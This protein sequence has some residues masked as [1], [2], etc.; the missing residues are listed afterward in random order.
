LPV[1][2]FV[3]IF[4]GCFVGYT[5]IFITDNLNRTMLKLKREV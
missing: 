4:T 1:L 2:S 5:S 3:S